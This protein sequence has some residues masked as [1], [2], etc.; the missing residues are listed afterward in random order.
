MASPNMTIRFE[1]LD[2]LKAL[3]ERWEAVCDRMEA[4]GAPPEWI[5]GIHFT[6]GSPPLERARAEFA[7]ETAEAGD[8]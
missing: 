2:E 8:E 4:L 3:V 1:N 5:A 6:H 7:L